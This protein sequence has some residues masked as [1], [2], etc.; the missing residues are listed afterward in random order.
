MSICLSV[1]QTVVVTL[2][3]DNTGLGF[4]VAGGRGTM[5]YRVDDEVSYFVLICASFTG[6]AMFN[7]RVPKTKLRFKVLLSICH[8]CW[9]LCLTLRHA[10]FFDQQEKVTLTCH[11]R[12]IRLTTELCALLHLVLVI[13][14]SISRLHHSKDI[15]NHICL[16]PPSIVSFNRE[17]SHTDIVVHLWG[18]SHKQLT[19]TATVNVGEFIFCDFVGKVYENVQTRQGIN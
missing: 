11:K 16:L 18:A 15:L 8:S 12:D 6:L 19:V 13:S 3:R 10:Q 2:H 7:T 17:H 4:S 14:G 9:R 5:P 1:C